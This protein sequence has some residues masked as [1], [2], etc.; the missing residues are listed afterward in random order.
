M[1]R[2]RSAR[3]APN[4]H[5]PSTSRLRGARAVAQGTVQLLVEHGAEVEVTDNNGQTGA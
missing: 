1:V 3:L 4:T 5:S 2:E